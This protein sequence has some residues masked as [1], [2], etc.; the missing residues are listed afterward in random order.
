MGG[1]AS[2][3]ATERMPTWLFGSLRGYDRS[4]LSGDLVAGTHRLGRPRARI[5]RVRHDRRGLAGR[6]AVRGAG[7]P[8][9]VRRVRQLPPSGGR[10]DVGHRRALRRGRRRRR[11]RTRPFVALHRDLRGQHRS[12]RSSPGCCGSGSSPSSSRARAEGLHRRARSHDHRRPAAEALRGREGEGDFFEKS[13]DL[14]RDLDDTTGCT[15]AS[16]S[17]RSRSSSGSGGSRP[18]SPAR[19]WRRCSA[20]VAVGASTSPT[21][22]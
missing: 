12:S 19:W 15:F 11:R 8:P 3:E 21:T 2:R 5:A 20:S 10:A 6:R 22:A 16:A 14:V 13:W 7:G 4:W 9:A 18:W 1:S 17:R